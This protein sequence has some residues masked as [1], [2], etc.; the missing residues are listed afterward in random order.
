[1][2]IKPSF[3]IIIITLAGLGSWGLWKINGEQFF[4]VSSPNQSQQASQTSED[5]PTGLV[6]I[7]STS[8]TQP[9]DSLNQ[10][11]Q[12]LSANK[13]SQAINFVNELYGELD[14]QELESLKRVF[15]Q[16]ALDYSDQG[17]LKRAQRFLTQVTDIFNEVEILDLLAKVSIDLGDW[18]SAFSAMLESSLIESQP[19]RLINKLSTL[20]NIASQLKN[21]FGASD[22]LENIR[23]LYQQLYDAHPSYAYFQFELALSYLNLGDINSAKPILSAI[24]YDIEVGPQAQDQLARLNEFAQQE[25]QDR[26]TALQE[27]NAAEARRRRAA[28]NR[29]DIAVSLIRSGN[30]F[31]VDSAIEGKSARLLLDTG[32][33]ITSFSPE[34]ISRLRLS[35]TGRSVRLS[36]ANGITESQLYLAK[37]INLGAISVQNLVVAEINLGDSRRFEGLLGTDLLN[38]VGDDYSYLIDNENNR[39]IFR[40][41]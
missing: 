7:I 37:R 38:K 33:S 21:D 41:R 27:Q 6:N 30:S 24:Q 2:N 9:S 26:Q 8:D 18:K 35:P 31:L 40:R 29:N 12:L 32:A 22:D 19:D 4:Q 3:L 5:K 10:V 28:L 20:A 16:K 14:S 25:L 36:T 11:Q 15:Y 23:K 39:L 13:T 17:E 1:M 34:L